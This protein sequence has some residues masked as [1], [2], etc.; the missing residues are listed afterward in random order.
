MFTT[1]VVVASVGVAALG[2][3]TALALHAQSLNA[4][5]FENGHCTASAVM[6]S[7]SIATRA[8]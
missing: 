3:G 8:R 6:T 1:G 2:A 5:A 7:G 4:Q